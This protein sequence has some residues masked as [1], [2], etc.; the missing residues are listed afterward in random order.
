MTDAISGSHQLRPRTP[1]SAPRRP[2]VARVDTDGGGGAPARLLMLQRAVGNR[3]TRQLF[4]QRCGSTP[5]DRCGCH[6]DDHGTASAPA[7]AAAAEPEHAEPPS[8]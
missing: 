3:A 1:A 7:T 4:V 2:A 5:A 8:A 6:G